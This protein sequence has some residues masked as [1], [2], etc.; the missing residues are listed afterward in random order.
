MKII[1]IQDAQKWFSNSGMV[2][3]FDEKTAR[4]LVEYVYHNA[5]GEIVAENEGRI[6]VAAYLRSVGQNPA[7]YNL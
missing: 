2:E 3:W 6:L 7:D 1:T 4:E 5:H